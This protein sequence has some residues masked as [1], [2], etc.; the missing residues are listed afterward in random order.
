MGAFFIPGLVVLSALVVF[1]GIA[2]AD[3]GL[4][5]HLVGGIADESGI[6]NADVEIGNSA[7]AT[8]GDYVADELLFSSDVKSYP[9]S[10]LDIPEFATVAGP[11]VSI[12]GLLLFFNHRKLREE[13]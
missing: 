8:K 6:G 9:R 11:L 12:L 1:A 4:K 10:V 3:D 2:A 7:T 5:S 13:N